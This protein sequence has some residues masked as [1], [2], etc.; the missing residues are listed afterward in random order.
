MHRVSSSVAVL[1]LAV[2]SSSVAIGAPAGS[3]VKTATMTPVCSTASGP[4]VWYVSS[5]KTYYVKGT[6]MY[7]KGTGKYVCRATAVSAGAKAGTSHGG[8]MS[9]GSM[10]HGSMQMP[11]TMA[12]QPMTTPGAMSPATPGGMGPG[13]TPASTSPAIPATPGAMSP[14][15]PGSVP[16]TVPGPAAPRPSPSP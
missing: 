1:A 13:T 3:I 7:G 10:G 5:T 12:P 6:A 16:G 9:P 11:M 4:V 2:A 14:A 15:T 8:A